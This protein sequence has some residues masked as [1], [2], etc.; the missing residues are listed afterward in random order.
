MLKTLVQS[1]IARFFPQFPKLDEDTFVLWEP[2]S[3]NHGEIIPG[4]AKYLLDMGYKV[5]VLMT[6]ARIPEGLFSHFD[7]PRLQL[8]RLT[9][10]QIRRFMK[11]DEIHKAAGILVTTA[12]KLPE[13]ADGAVDFGAVFGRHTPR[14]LLMVEHD[15]RRRL[16]AGQWVDTNI[17]LRALDLLNA[18][19]VVVNPH[20]FGNIPD[21]E[22]NTGKTIFV[23]AGAARSKRRNQD[24]VLN[25]V[26][27]LLS[28][29]ETAFELRLIGKPGKE[30]LPDDL[31]GHVVEIGRIPF[32]RLYQEIE[33]SDFILTAFQ[34]N[35]P[36]HAFY[37]TTGTTGSFQLAYGFHKPCIV[38]S[39]FTSGTVLNNQN[40]LFYD[41]DSQI[42][43]CMERAIQMTAA[44]HRQMRQSM[45]HAARD[46]SEMSLSNLRALV[47]G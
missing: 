14:R 23:M 27:T 24:M 31:K 39:D 15:A 44:H 19:S 1:A 28:K 42:L 35:N 38:Q 5:L 2:C 9:Q 17:T 29:G 46:L 11:T 25:A 40:S 32:S 41:D 10:R 6:P 7:H 30:P 4:Y 34:R 16:E 26:R 43:D 33:A 3:K 37:R 8:G 12:G 47:D 45:A 22:K 13:R 36:D 21:H 20:Y 18:P